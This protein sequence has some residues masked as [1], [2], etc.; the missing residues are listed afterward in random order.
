MNTASRPV[1]VAWVVGAGYLGSR[2]HEL[3]LGGGWD[4]RRVDLEPSRADVRADAAE[5]SALR[6][7]GLPRPDCVFSCVSTAGGGADA[8][9]RLYVGV[10]ASLRVCCCGARVVFCSSSSVYGASDASWVT[11]ESPCR[12]STRRGAVL[13]KAEE[14]V[15]RAGGVVARLCALYGPKRSCAVL[16]YLRG[17]DILAGDDDRWINHIHRDDAAAA[18]LHLALTAPP[19]STWNVA[20]G[21]PMQK[22]QML[23]LLLE[24]TGLPLPSGGAR[25]YRRGVSNQ[26][27]SSEKLRASGWLPVYPRF[28][29]ALE[30]VLRSFA[31]LPD[32]ED[33]GFG[34]GAST[35]FRGK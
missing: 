28:A 11:E 20:D 15:R 22:G 3:L 14:E 23:S 16:R 31:A 6:R 29:C 24:S 34:A 9:E 4:S 13:L 1:P 8:Y 26:R 33:D 25:P 35:W 27:V 32:A 21:S 17:G 2:L 7:A 12:P 5:A 10:A 19:G 30:E 18:L